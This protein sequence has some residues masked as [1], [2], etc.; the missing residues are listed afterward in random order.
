MQNSSIKYSDKFAKKKSEDAKKA[1]MTDKE[2]YVQFLEGQLEKMTNAIL[3]A[4]TLEER[5]SKLEDTIS[6]QDEKN[7]KL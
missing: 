5:V 2:F 1:F 6:K 3:D 4:K 7:E